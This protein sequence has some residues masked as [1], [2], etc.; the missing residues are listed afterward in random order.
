MRQSF[1]DPNCRNE[2]LVRRVE[3]LPQEDFS[4]LR[5]WAVKKA[6]EVFLLPGMSVGMMR[7]GEGVI[8]TYCEPWLYVLGVVL[9]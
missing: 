1:H 8:V 6:R 9:R 5:S 3:R 2:S 7:C 4:S